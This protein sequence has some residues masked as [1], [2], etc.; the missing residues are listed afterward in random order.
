MPTGHPY[1]GAGG[2]MPNYPGGYHQPPMQQQPQQHW[3][4]QQQGMVVGRICL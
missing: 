4:Q 2:M 3:Q 1:S